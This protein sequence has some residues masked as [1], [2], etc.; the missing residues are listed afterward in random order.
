MSIQVVPVSVT[1]KITHLPHFH[2]YTTTKFFLT[3]YTSSY[4]TSSLSSPSHLLHYNHLHPLAFFSTTPPPP[5][6]YPPTVR[7]LTAPPLILPYV[8]L[9]VEH[10]PRGRTPT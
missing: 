5:Q 2:P 7:T 10:A 3:I 6:P 8:T 9:P 1:N 4:M